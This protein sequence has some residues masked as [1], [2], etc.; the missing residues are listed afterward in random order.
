MTQ[1]LDAPMTGVIEADETYHGGKPHPMAGQL[2]TST[3]G[4]GTLKA[5][6]G[7]DVPLTAPD[8]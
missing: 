6:R 1:G 3:R 8:A 2:R 5:I 4:R 7:A